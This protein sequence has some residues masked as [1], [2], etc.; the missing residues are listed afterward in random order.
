M[1]KQH[2]QHVQENI[3]HIHTYKEGCK[4]KP[5]TKKEEPKTAKTKLEPTSAETKPAKSVLKKILSPD[6][7]LQEGNAKLRVVVTGGKLRYKSR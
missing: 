4:K 7:K 2:V 5:A 6:T 1:K 3:V